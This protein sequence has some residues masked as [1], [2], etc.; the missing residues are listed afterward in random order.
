MS[1]VKFLAPEDTAC[2]GCCTESLTSSSDGSQAVEENSLSYTWGLSGVL[3]VSGRFGL[4]WRE[5][6]TRERVYLL[7]GPPPPPSQGRCSSPPPP[8]KMGAGGG[9]R[10]GINLTTQK[11][12]NSLPW[13]LKGKQSITNAHTMRKYTGIK[14]EKKVFRNEL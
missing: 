10:W 14:G 3:L 7:L 8:T 4:E 13:C 12:R 5:Y 9:G 2:W 1:S 6:Y 11:M